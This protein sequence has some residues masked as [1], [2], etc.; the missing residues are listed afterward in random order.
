MGYS[1]RTVRC[2]QSQADLVILPLKGKMGRAGP[3][4][5]PQRFCSGFSHAASEVD[6]STPNPTEHPETPHLGTLAVTE[7]TPNSLRLSWGVA[8]GPFDSFVVQYQDTEGQPQALLVDG[9]QDKVLISDL[10]PSTSYKFFLYGLSQGTRH[11]PV[12]AEGTTG[13]AGLG[14]VEGDIRSGCHREGM[15]K[16]R[17]GVLPLPQA[18]E[19]PSCGSVPH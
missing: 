6:T 10:K 14:R 4:G 17:E 13:R 11:G 16:H 8:R 19:H 2:H 1:A 5:P 9:N 12:S 3:R 7:A 15:R 18:T